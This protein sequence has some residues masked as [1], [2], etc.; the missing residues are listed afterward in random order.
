M[1]RTTAQGDGAGPRHSPEWYDQ[2]SEF[3]EL[4]PGDRM[5]I[6]CIGGPCTSRLEH[7]PPRLE[8]RERGGTYTLVDV[9]PRNEWRYEF[10]PD[11]HA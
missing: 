5:F 9:G 2:T 1:P 8:I 7:F 4:R 10:V 3:I 11:H 6:P